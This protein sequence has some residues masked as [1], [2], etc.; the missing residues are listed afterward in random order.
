MWEVNGELHPA[1]YGNPWDAVISSASSWIEWPASCTT[2]CTVEFDAYMTGLGHFTRQDIQW[3]VAGMS[4]TAQKDGHFWSCAVRLSPT[5]CMVA[6]RI[7]SHTVF[8]IPDCRWTA[9]V[10][11]EHSA[12]WGSWFD[13]P[14]WQLKVG[15]VGRVYA[16]SKGLDISHNHCS[17]VFGSSGGSNGSQVCYDYYLVWTDSTGYHEEYL[18][19]QCFGDEM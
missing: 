11:T 9:K 1:G 18:G 3:E 5:N 10:Q 2:W 16:G 7:D 15:R 12:W 19:T 17:P 4:G 6:E 8:S 13:I 14:L